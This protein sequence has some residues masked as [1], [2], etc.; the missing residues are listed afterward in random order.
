MNFDFS[1]LITNRTDAASYLAGDINRVSDCMD[2]LVE[3]LAGRGVL[4]PG[5]QRLPVPD[6]QPDA[7]SLR[8]T[9]NNWPTPKAVAAQLGNVQKMR[10]ALAVEKFTPDVP[11]AISRSL[12]ANNIEQILLAVEQ[13]LRSMEK[14][15]LYAAQPLLFGGFL[16]YPVT[17]IQRTEPEEPAVG[18]RLYTA[19]GLPVYTADGF[20]VYFEN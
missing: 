20:A 15:Y 18:L 13:S 2:A 5:Y 14:I 6:G 17:Q 4:V 1:A 19:D 8:W 9:E 11:Q 10:N 12:E 3:E 7:G 16:L